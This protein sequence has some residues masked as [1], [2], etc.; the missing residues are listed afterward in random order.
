MSSQV[1]DDE[2]LDADDLNAVDSAPPNARELRPEAAAQLLVDALRRR[3]GATFAGRSTVTGRAGRVLALLGDRLPPQDQL[4]ALGER[5][6]TRT[7]VRNVLRAPRAFVLGAPAAYARF[8]REELRA[9][10]LFLPDAGESL[11][12]QKITAPEVDVLI[13]V[14]LKNA[15]TLLQ[16]N[17][18]RMSAAHDWMNKI[19]SEHRL[20]VF[21]DEATDFSAV[22]LACTIELSHPRVRS[23]FACGDL[24]QRITEHGVQDRG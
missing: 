19:T 24:N 6:V 9:G 2:E 21:V 7:A 16:A 1:D 8:R 10:A 5:I 4:V 3:A 13:L 23:W 11:R 15:R 18:W 20:Q 12:S 22:Q 14:M 17:A